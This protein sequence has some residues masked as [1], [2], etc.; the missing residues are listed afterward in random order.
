ML[1]LNATLFPIGLLRQSIVDAVEAFESG[2][3]ETL[4]AT[5]GIAGTQALAAEL[6]SLYNA[7]IL[8]YVETLEEPSMTRFALQ[9][10]KVHEGQYRSCLYVFF[11]KVPMNL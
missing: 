9:A 5:H 10:Y 6:R 2:F 3:S 7:S 11:C 4:A 8:K 1:C